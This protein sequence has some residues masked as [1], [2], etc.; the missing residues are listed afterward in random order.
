M[1]EIDIKKFSDNLDFNHMLEMSDVDNTLDGIN[2]SIVE[3][4][5]KHAPLLI[6]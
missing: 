4:S 6:L 1:K 5:D 3:A 2:F